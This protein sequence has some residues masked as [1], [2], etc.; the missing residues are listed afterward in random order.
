[1]EMYL[2][3]AIRPMTCTVLLHLVIFDKELSLSG[4]LHYQGRF[5]PAISSLSGTNV[6][7]RT[8]HFFEIN[9]FFL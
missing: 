3:S 9:P 5:S 4:N 7:F 8:I 2:H 6:Y 1:V